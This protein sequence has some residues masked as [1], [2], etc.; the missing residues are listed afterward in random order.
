VLP[1]DVIVLPDEATA[2]ERPDGSRDAAPGGAE[3]RIGTEPGVYRVLAGD[4][5]AAALAVNPDPAAS[6]L[7]RLD[8]R[9][10]VARLPGWRLHVTSD[11]A[12]WR[13]AIFRER[14][15]REFWK[16]LVLALLLVLAVETAVAAAGPV[17]G[18][19]PQAARA[20]EGEPG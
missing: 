8:R 14:I 20:S 12:G 16:P 10:L 17:R 13:R 9:S 18:A 19:T 15:G 1:G 6:R 5:V 7:A 4:T 3:Y 11:A 2:V